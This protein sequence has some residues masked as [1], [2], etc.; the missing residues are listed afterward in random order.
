ME[1]LKKIVLLIDSDNT[2]HSK[3]KPVIDRISTYGRIV[4]KKAYGDWKNP[5]LK[6]W[7]PL[8]KR[9]AIKAEQQFAYVV[10][11]NAT[12]MAMVIDAMDLL[13]S[14]MYDSF[15]LVSS[16]S[17]FTPLAIRLR[18]SGVYVFGVGEQKTA[19]SFRNACDNFIFLE[20]LPED[21]GS[22]DDNAPPAP[23]VSVKEQNAA[24]CT[25]SDMCGKNGI[26]TIH[27]LLRIA[28]EEY[29]DDN[30]YA[31]ISAAG[32]YLKRA[33][34][35]FNIKSYGYSKLPELLRA[36]PH[37]YKVI[38]YKGSGTVKIVAYKCL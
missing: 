6:N 29:Q 9:L 28:Y 17:D 5:L 18:E 7:E 38:D 30:G 20:Y 4:V 19:Q 1:E 10:K 15:A 13:H 37:K 23:A 25:Q 21:D 14:G 36:F 24:A 26:E 3:L 11:K 12:D 27:E 22:D 33:K 8:L 2:Q 31:N 16:D 32:S 35:D 34:P